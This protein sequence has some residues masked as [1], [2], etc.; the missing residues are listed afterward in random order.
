MAQPLHEVLCQ[1]F[2]RIVRLKL[3]HTHTH[4]STKSGRKRPKAKHFKLAV[5]EIFLLLPSQIVPL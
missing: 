1:I 5:Y 3:T 2:T 4:N